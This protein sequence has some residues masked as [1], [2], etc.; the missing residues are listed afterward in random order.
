[1]QYW[2]FD[3]KKRESSGW[4]Y[5]FQVFAVEYRACRQRERNAKCLRREE[6]RCE[7]RGVKII[8]L[9]DPCHN[10]IH[11]RAILFHSS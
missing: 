8:A 5:C 2:I 1:M 4:L 9:R 11:P 6:Y 3:A 10:P 7:V